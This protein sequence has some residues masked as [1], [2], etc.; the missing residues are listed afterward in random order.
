MAQTQHFT[1][2]LTSEDVRRV[3]GRI[4]DWKVEDII[5]TGADLRALEEAAAWAAGDDETTPR[6]HLPPHGVAAQ[7][8]DILTAGEAPEGDDTANL[9]G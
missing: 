4:P 1:P 5:A 6:R 8:F 9:A 2:K 7:V 3:C